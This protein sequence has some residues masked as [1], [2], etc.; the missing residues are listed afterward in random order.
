MTQSDSSPGYAHYLPSSFFS[1][2]WASLNPEVLSKFLYLTFRITV[3][4]A[5]KIQMFKHKYGFVE[6]EVSR[7][8]IKTDLEFIK[9]VDWMDN[10][11][12]YE[13]DGWR[14][15]SEKV[16]QGSSDTLVDKQDIINQKYTEFCT[17]SNNL[18]KEFTH[19]YKIAPEQSRFVQLMGSMT[20]FYWTA[21]LKDLYRF[22][23]LRSASDA[24]KE[25]RDIADLINGFIEETFPITWN[26]LKLAK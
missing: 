20:M 1:D 14:E 2:D 11:D 18:Y 6:S 3:P 17:N 21:N 26:S 13:T 24:Q 4:Q 15:L 8:Y 22:Y 23:V 10:V 7:R 9:E 12:Y 25:V 16:K 5:I 19:E